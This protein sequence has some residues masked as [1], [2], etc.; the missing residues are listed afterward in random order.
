MGPYRA[1]K[2]GSILYTGN[3]IHP[4][5][6]DVRRVHWPPQGLKN[7]VRSIHN[8]K[9]WFH[10]HKIDASIFNAA[11]KFFEKLGADWV[12]LP[13]TTLMISSPGEVYA[14]QKLDYTTDTLPLEISNWFH[15]GRRAFLSESSQFYLELRLVIDGLDKVFSIYN[16]FRK[17]PADLTHLSEFQHIEFEGHVGFNENIQI[18]LDLI[19]YIINF[20]LKKNEYDL[21]FFLNKKDLHELEAGVKRKVIY[22][23]FIEILDTLFK[24]TGNN[25]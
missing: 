25:S 2:D 1:K 13:L 4:P 23:P 8:E 9:K 16:S 14:G 24:E 20:L 17:E 7:Q 6:A 3:K 21:S 10:L 19:D 18:F 12:N 15:T 11:T 5:I 22:I